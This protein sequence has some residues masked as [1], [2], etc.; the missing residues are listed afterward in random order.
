MK[1]FLL[2]IVVLA[3]TNCKSHTSA[4]NTADLYY[5]SMKDCRFSFSSID[6]GTQIRIIA[7]SGGE[8]S[9]KETTFY[10]QFIGVTNT[11]DTIRITPLIST[12]EQNT[13]T[14][15]TLYNHDKGIETATIQP[16]NSSFYF[17]INLLAQS[18]TNGESPITTGDDYDKLQQKSSADEKIVMVKNIPLFES[19]RYKTVVGALHFDEVPW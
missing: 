18:K 2:L 15:P 12:G 17:G 5:I 13:W 16:Q 4:N 10:D 11:Q 19:S 8:E 6:S 1:F 7:F 3:L 9:T 14:T